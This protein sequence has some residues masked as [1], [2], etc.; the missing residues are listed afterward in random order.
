MHQ[1]H[2]GDCAEAMASMESNSVDAIVTVHHERREFDGFDVDGNTPNWR[3]THETEQVPAKVW[4][5]AMSS[6]E[7]LVEWEDGTLGAVKLW[8]IRLVSES[9]A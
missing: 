3:Y 7:L 8:D 4:P 6:D 5:V 9:D 2:N 1:I